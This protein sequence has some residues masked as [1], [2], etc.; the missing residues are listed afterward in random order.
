M[1]VNFNISKLNH[2]IDHAYGNAQKN[3]GHL[4]NKIPSILSVTLP[5]KIEDPALFSQSQMRVLPID[6]WNAMIPLLDLKTCRALLQTSKLMHLVVHNYVGKFFPSDWKEDRFI[7]TGVKKVGA[8]FKLKMMKLIENSSKSAIPASNFK[9]LI[10]RPDFTWPQL[11]AEAAERGTK[12][13]DNI[14][15]KFA[16]DWK[17]NLDVAL[18]CSSLIHDFVGVSAEKLEKLLEENSIQLPTV[19][20][21]AALYIF[22]EKEHVPW[23]RSVLASSQ[24]EDKINWMMLFTNDV[25]TDNFGNKKTESEL[26]M[27]KNPA[28]DGY[29]R[30]RVSVQGK[31]GIH[32]EVQAPTS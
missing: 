5:F 7:N 17:S 26:R 18:I 14:F 13:H 32:S 20:E 28:I 1:S 15:D 25:I 19:F 16:E 6:M 11:K 30:Y 27:G 24:S 8:L 12:I 31:I 10:M 21:L 3:E 22:S 29:Y 23:T 4:D 2:A 9:C